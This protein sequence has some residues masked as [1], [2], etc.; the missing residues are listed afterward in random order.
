MATCGKTVIKAKDAQ[1]NPWSSIW[2]GHRKKEI[3]M[4]NFS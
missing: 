3:I 2:S 1:V 4:I